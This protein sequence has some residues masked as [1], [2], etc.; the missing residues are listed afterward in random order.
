MIPTSTFNL[1]L[2]V[3][4]LLFLYSVID[5]KN[6]I[7]SNI[8]TSTVAGILFM[9]LSQA[10]T[11]GASTISSASV[12]DIAALFGWISFGYAV[13]MAADAVFEVIN[14]EKTDT[15]PGGEP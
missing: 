3:A 13:F 15:N 4:V 7:Y 2:A 5:N 8:V 1:L 14:A 11:I 6:N 10:A 12:G 9:W